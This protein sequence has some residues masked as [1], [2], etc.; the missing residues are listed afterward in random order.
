LLDPD[1]FIV[2]PDWPAGGLPS[3]PLNYRDFNIRTKMAVVRLLQ[4]KW[5]KRDGKRPEVG[6]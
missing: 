6:P 2:Q 4:R 1:F 3:N 5:A